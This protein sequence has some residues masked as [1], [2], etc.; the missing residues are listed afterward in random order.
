MPEPGRS[1]IDEVRDAALD[2]TVSVADALRKLIALGGEA[3][4]ADLREW[5]S[6]E[7]RGYVGSGV[8]IPDYRKPGAVIQV[9][10]IRGNYQLTGHQ[11]STGTLPE[12]V[13]DVVGEEIPLG[14][15]IGEIEALAASA[16][17]AGGHIRMTIPG[18]QDVVAM[19]N[20]EHAD[21]AYQHFQSV[22]WSV[23]APALEGVVDRVRTTL[24]ELVAEM[25]AA[26]PSSSVTPPAAVADQAVNVVVRG[27]GSRVNL[28]TAQASGS[29][30]HE[31]HAAPPAPTPGRSWW[32]GIWGALVGLATVI[33]T[34]VAVAVWQGWGL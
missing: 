34:L 11:I 7:L 24:V 21:V 33:G 4:S 32:K 9:D 1:L 3:G 13:R 18:S 16:R 28:T 2:P 27:I 19:M 12:G 17:S 22:Y 29:G 10:A 20:H 8:E 23:S 6:R 30:D 31:L 25:R 14:Q 26:M 15:G 5:A